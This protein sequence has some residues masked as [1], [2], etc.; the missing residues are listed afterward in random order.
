MTRLDIA[1]RPFSSFCVGERATVARQITDEDIRQ[2]AE[3]SGDHNGLHTDSAYAATTRYGKRVAHGLLIAA[4]ISAM[5][6]HLLPGKRCVLLGSNVRF[7][8]PVF[9]GDRLTYQGTI[10][11]ISK[12]TRVL[13]VQ[14][15]VTNQTGT[16][17]LRGGYEGQV[18]HAPGGEQT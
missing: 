18:L 14:I 7:L 8:Q 5:A 17:V 1:D 15:E 2:F 13:K 12:A 16:V 3:L 9:P 6:G 4:P 10:T 11:H